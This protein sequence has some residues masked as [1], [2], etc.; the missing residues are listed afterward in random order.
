MYLVVRRVAYGFMMME[1]QKPWSPFCLL[2][3][4]LQCSVLFG[5]VGEAPSITEVSQV[6]LVAIVTIFAT[7]SLHYVFRFGQTENQ[8]AKH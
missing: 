8:D 6:R 4:W 2:I 3:L 5:C 7:W 1:P